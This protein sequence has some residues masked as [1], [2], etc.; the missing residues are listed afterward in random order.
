MVVYWHPKWQQVAHWPCYCITVRVSTSHD[1]LNRYPRS[2][3]AL[4][5]RSLVILISITSTIYHSKAG[6]QSREKAQPTLPS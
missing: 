4:V 2:C 1:E 6:P 5:R 3:E